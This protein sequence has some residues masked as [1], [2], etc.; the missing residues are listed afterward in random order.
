[1]TPILMVSEKLTFP[2]PLLIKL[3]ETFRVVGTFALE[4]HILAFDQKCGRSSLLKL[5]MYKMKQVNKKMFYITHIKT[6]TNQMI[7]KTVAFY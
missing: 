5:D 2:G 6:K 7:S 4:W 1:M 3:V